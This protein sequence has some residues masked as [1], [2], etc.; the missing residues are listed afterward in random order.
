MSPSPKLKVHLADGELVKWPVLQFL[1]QQGLA[2]EIGEEAVSAKYTIRLGVVTSGASTGA[3]ETR[4][5][6]YG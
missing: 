5:F 3:V 6:Q 2:M 4:S 1:S